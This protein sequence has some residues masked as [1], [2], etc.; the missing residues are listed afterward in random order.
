MGHGEGAIVEVDGT[1]ADQE[2]LAAG[3]EELIIAGAAYQLATETCLV[4]ASLG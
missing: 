4:E 3:A 1:V 2:V